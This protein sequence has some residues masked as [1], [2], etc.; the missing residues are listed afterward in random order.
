MTPPA[1]P[2]SRTAQSSPIKGGAA[3][4]R[5]P[6]SSGGSERSEPTKKKGMGVKEMEAVSTPGSLRLVTCR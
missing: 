6:Q 3:D 5:R 1:E 2:P 4:A